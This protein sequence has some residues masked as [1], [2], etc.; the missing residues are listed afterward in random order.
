MFI[1]VLQLE[2]KEQIAVK[3]NQLHQKRI[4]EANQEPSAWQYPESE[5]ADDE[6]LIDL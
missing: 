2:T 6:W 4:Q 3:K 5:D 1:N